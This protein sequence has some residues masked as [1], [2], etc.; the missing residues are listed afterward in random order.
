MEDYQL[1]AQENPTCG[2]P[3][4]YQGIVP[5][6]GPMSTWVLSSL[7]RRVLFTSTPPSP[8]D[9]LFALPVLS[10]LV[11]GRE[12]ET[13]REKYSELAPAPV[14][15]AK[16]IPGLAGCRLCCLPCLGIVHECLHSTPAPDRFTQLASVAERPLGG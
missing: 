11:G 7:F 16:T 6:S 15:V 13:K 2:T 3:C 5:K 12:R 14:H 4:L 10:L 8:P 1:S 9:L